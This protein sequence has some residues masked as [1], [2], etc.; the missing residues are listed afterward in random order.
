MFVSM[1]G[2][3]YPQARRLYSSVKVSYFLFAFFIV[4]SFLSVSAK[5][6]DAYNS[7]APASADTVIF[8]FGENSGYYGGQFTDQQIFDLGYAGGSRTARPVFSIQQYLQYGVA[9]FAPRFNYPYQTKGMRNNVMTLTVDPYGGSYAG[10]STVITAGGNQCMLPA[11]LYAPVFNADSSI[12]TNN[13]WAKFVA[14][15]YNATQGSFSTYEAFNEPDINNDYV[16]SQYDSSTGNYNTWATRAP[17]P[18]ELTN[19]YDSITAEVRLQQIT[20]QVIHH[21]S[22]NTVRVATGGI[23]LRY[24]WRQALKAGI[25]PYVDVL[26]MHM[27][28]YYY[29]TYWT[30]QSPLGTG[31]QRYS[32]MLLRVNDSLYN[33]MQVISMQNGVSANLPHMITETNTPRWN[34][35]NNTATGTQNKRVG[36]DHVQRN[37]ALKGVADYWRKGFAPIVWFQTGEAADS[38]TAS[39]TEFDAQGMYKNL[40]TAAPGS[41]VF[42]QSG[43]AMQ[44]MQRLCGNYSM[45]ATQ[46]TWPTGIDGILLDSG[47]YKIYMIW[48]KTYL[49]LNETAVGTYTLPTG[50]IYKQYIWDGTS[51][52]TATGIVTLSGDPYFLVESTTGSAVTAN[53]GINQTIVLPINSVLLSGVLSTVS[54]S[55]IS[56]YAWSQVSGPATASLSAA[57]AVST[58]AGS[59]VAGTYVFS[60]KVKDA[61]NDSATATV[62]VTVNPAIINL[63]PVVSAGTAQTITL[64]T[65]TV[66]LTGSATDAGTITAY[67]WTQVSGPSTATIAT[68]SAAK[69]AVSALVAGT[70]VFQL[71]ATDNNNLS[72]TATVTI[73]VNA[74]L[75]PPVVTAGTAQTITLPTSTVTLTG[76]ATDEGTITAYAWTQ[77]SG[78][79]TA[80]IAT[81]SAAKTAVSALVAGTYVFQLKATDNNNLS[82]TATVTITVNAA[83]QPPVVSAGTAQTIT[84]PTSTVTL[85]G[86]ATDASGTITTYAWTQVSGPSTATIATAS[87]ATTTVS[88]LVAGSYV[89]QL[90]VTDNNSLSGTATVTI[91]VNPAPNQPPVANAGADQTIT[92]PVNSLTLNGSASIDPDGTIVSYSWVK[93]SGPASGT[94]VS[95]AGATTVVNSLVQGTYSFKLTVT[96]NSGATDTDT[97]KITVNAAANQPP[98]ANA[99]TSKTITLPTNSVSL[100]G[101]KSADPDGT[102][103]SYKWSEVSGPSAATITSGTTATPTVSSLVAG[104][105]IFQLIVTDNS[106]ATSTAQVKVIVNPAVNIPPVANAGADQTITLPV[107]SVTLDGTGS[108]DPD[109]TIAGYNWVKISGPASGTIVSATSATTLVNNLVQGTYSYQ[110]TVT[111]NSGATDVDTVTVTVNAAANQPPVANA[112]SSKTITLPASSVSLDGTKST[113]PDGTIA[114]YS[115]SQVSGPSTAT[116][117]N[118][119]TA[120]PTVSSLIAGTYIFQMTVTDNSGATSTAQV[121]V[122]VNPAANVNPIANAGAN[123]TITLPLDSVTL[124]G[125]ASQDPNGTIV[126]YSWVKISGP[127]SGTIVTPTGVTTLVNTLVQGTYVYK[128][129]VTDN[130]GNTASDSVTIT[131]KAAIN[132]APIANAGSGKTIT[133]PTDSVSLD[134]TKSYDPDGTIASYNWVELLGPSTA[135]ISNGTTATPLVGALQAGNYY[136]QLTVTD[137]SG[138]TSK[139]TVKITVRPAVNQPPV[140]NAGANQT[141]T[142][143]LD[144]V[145]LDGSASQDPDGTIATFSWVKISGPTSGTIVSAAN[146]ITIANNLVQ[147]TYIYKLTVTDNKGA[148]STDTVTITVNAAANQP[149]VANAGANKTITLPT[150]SVSLD[151]SGSSDP[152]GTIASYKW[153]ELSGPSAA[154]ITNGNT[155]SPTVS[156]LIAGTYI[157]QLAVTDNSGVTSNAQV[158]VI[159]RAAANQ[160]PVAN[161]GTDQT[162]TLPTTSV[163]LDGSKSSDPDGTIASYNWSKISGAGS[164]TITNS[165]TAKPT[166]SGLQAGVYVFQLTVTDNSGATSTDN[167]TITVNAAPIAN[168]AP[169]ANAGTNQSIKLPASTVTL[170]GTKS[171][172]PD[173][174]ITSYNWIEISGPS[175]ATISNAKTATA[176][177]AGLLSAG[178]YNFKLTV[179]DNK[180]ATGSAQVTTTVTAASANQPPVANAGSDQ[181][182]TLPANSASLDGTKSTDPDGTIASY[183]WVEVSGPTTATIGNS[184]TATPT[185]SGLQAGAYTFKLTV[186][187]NSGATATDQVIITVNA[188]AVVQ[189]NKLIANAGND[190]TIGLPSTATVLNASAS[191]DVGG[192]ITGYEWVQ[193]SGP[194]FATIASAS[195][196]ITNVSDLLT[197]QYVFLVT[198]T[199]N[200]GLT[201]TDS[202]KVTVVN[203]LRS[204][205]QSMLLYPNPAQSTINLRLISDSTGSTKLS[206]I[207]AAGRTAMVI[208]RTKAQAVLNTSINVSGLAKGMYSMQVLI[209]TQTVMIGKFLKQ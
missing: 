133:L 98:V 202:V 36:N 139:A 41:T 69:T 24:W 111:D 15:V 141:I 205:A 99:G 89:F 97:V 169:I 70:Y 145:T 72:A 166:V 194:A 5:N 94:I 129:T 190:T 112:G 64:P 45:Y 149:P 30:N 56:S 42:T 27:Y 67:A 12:N 4:F 152:D 83:L 172:D 10:Q 76:S 66:T 165:N 90:K 86:S 68:A 74:A 179:T 11:S 137:N 93:I 173:G 178:S 31:N 84:L 40:K 59:L 126:G 119:N 18:D 22:H 43:Q 123:Q 7:Y 186:T 46:P 142:L 154:T 109:G 55:T 197:G 50:K 195:S 3:F 103:A 81:A 26:S 102:I 206:I 77:V 87:A 117:T 158:K 181:T 164:I 156:S 150:N 44:T 71:K 135:T 208:E 113:D 168:Q 6:A 39:A 73:T 171:Y 19:V 53:A 200:N 203:N 204:S 14:D 63:P 49:D 58:T 91:T 138:A 9:P 153:T 2:K 17:Y 95:A 32:D 143:P 51:P 92:L 162:I 199:D 120:S 177:V 57:N 144:S 183:N 101:T 25:G 100:D 114:S 106:G 23:S 121:K 188:A 151:G 187:D 125:S 65:S 128:L 180:G 160:P 110:L 34:Y 193:V 85:K 60:L 174:T 16:A 29:W 88:A 192:T 157:F 33:G 108:I 170:D 115:W 127:A 201:S 148:M 146:A 78:P 105:Y 198:V 147:G 184:T 96:D 28:P 207:D 8:P 161:A 48:A 47:G 13:L 159:V 37:Y 54:N 136:F 20:W 132:K 62:T 176:T 21:L 130:S 82:A 185:V 75:L 131:V 182:I 140:A 209:G 104:T 1:K 124:D 163:T 122:T 52:G 167:V 61:N 107:N 191:T 155:A 175:N 118:G 116:I 35:D 79:S 134:G 189:T 80:T 38:G 196:S